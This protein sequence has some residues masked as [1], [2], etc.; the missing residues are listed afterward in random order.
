MYI[1]NGKSYGSLTTT[2]NCLTPT[3][4]LMEIMT[5]TDNAFN[6]CSR[7]LARLVDSFNYN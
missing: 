7:A 1:A 2:M 6:S 4:S 5:H 3:L